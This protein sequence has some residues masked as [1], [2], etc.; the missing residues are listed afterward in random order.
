MPIMKRRIRQPTPMLVLALSS[1]AGDDDDSHSCDKANSDGNDIDDAACDSKPEPSAPSSAGRRKSSYGAAGYSSA[2]GINDEEE[3]RRADAASRKK[4]PKHDDYRREQ[5]KPE[6]LT[7]ISISS[8]RCCF[9]WVEIDQTRGSFL[10]LTGAARRRT[11][12]DALTFESST[13]LHPTS[14]PAT[15]TQPSNA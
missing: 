2:S 1:E 12:S 8:R 13:V 11:V 3:S 4:R 7:S 15:S 14:A 9:E 5:L 6:L 10:Y